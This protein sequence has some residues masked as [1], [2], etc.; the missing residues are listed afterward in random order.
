MGGTAELDIIKEKGGGNDKNIMYSK[1][2]EHYQKLISLNNAKNNVSKRNINDDTLS[3]TT[4]EKSIAHVKKLIIGVSPS[5]SV[6]ILNKNKANTAKEIMYETI[7]EEVEQKILSRQSTRRLSNESNDDDDDS[8]NFS[9]VNDE[10]KG[11]DNDDNESDDDDDSDDDFDD[12]GPIEFPNITSEEYHLGEI[13]CSDSDYNA[14]IDYF[15]SAYDTYTNATTGS[16]TKQSANDKIIISCMLLERTSMCYSLK[17]NSSY[18]QSK[19]YYM[20]A[21]I[22]LTKNFSGPI[23][24]D[25]SNDKKKNKKNKKEW[26]IGKIL[27]FRI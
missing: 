12:D 21:I 26:I 3:N 1:S 13:K 14:A 10:N 11:S 16:I 20:D 24:K 5:Q 19:K 18:S 7:E 27:L 4:L 9:I 8:F 6:Y 25:F 15:M 2:I 17:N 22:M 23:P